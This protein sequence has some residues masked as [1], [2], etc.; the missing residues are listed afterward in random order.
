VELVAGGLARARGA[1][2]PALT[3]AQLGCEGRFR[4]EKTERSYSMGAALAVAVLDAETGHPTITRCM[5]VCDVGRAV[6]PL[7]VDGQLAGAAAQG[8]GGALLEEFAYGED[9]Q[10][11]STSFMDYCLPTAAELPRIEAI[12]LELEQHRAESANPLGVKGAGEG[13][14]VGVGAAVGNAVADAIGAAGHGLT[15]LPLTP[16]RVRDLLRVR[17]NPS[18]GGVISR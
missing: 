10:P 2:E 15:R 14:I 6:N 12:A 16:E 4:Y 9:G 3:F 11:H 1:V 5:V 8:I 18:P 17:E 13:G 7:I